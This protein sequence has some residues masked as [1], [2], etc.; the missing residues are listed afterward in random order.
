MFT[1]HPQLA[2]DT[3]VVTEL[4]LSLVLLSRDANYPWFILVPAIA[5][6]REL[7]HLDVAEQQLVLRESAR[8]A[9]AIELLYAPHKLNVAALGNVVE[10]L[11]VH[12]I[13]RFTTDAAWP[14]PVWGRLAAAPYPA[15]E[16]DARA[17]AMAAQLA[18]S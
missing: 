16:L 7:H 5:G 11:H 12:H 4:E 2:A 18:T 8:L 10:Q 14:A 6:A 1:L 9:N 17:A 15:G 3:V 13:A